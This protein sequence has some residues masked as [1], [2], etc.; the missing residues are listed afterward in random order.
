MYVYD[1]KGVLLFVFR[2][3]Q[4]AIQQMR[5][6]HTSL[7]QCTQHQMLYLNYFIFGAA[8]S[9]MPVYECKSRF[10]D[11]LAIKRKEYKPKNHKWAKTVI[12]YDVKR[13]RSLLFDSLRSACRKLNIDRETL[14]AYL[15]GGKKV[16]KNT[17]C[18]RYK[19]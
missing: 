2:T 6:H 10:L 3:K 18:F 4:E 17:W 16:Y 11:I 9:V 13:K 14:R 5:I 12:A 8:T 7:N 1:L 15:K 19:I